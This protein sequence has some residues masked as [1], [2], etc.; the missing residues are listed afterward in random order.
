MESYTVNKIS[1]DEG[2]FWNLWRAIYQ[3]RIKKLNLTIF[4][5]N[6]KT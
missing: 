2:F 4:T 6:F 3:R 5:H 1:K